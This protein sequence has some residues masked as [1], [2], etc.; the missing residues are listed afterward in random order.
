[1]IC[2]P[3]VESDLK[4]DNVIINMEPEKLLAMVI[5]SREYMNCLEI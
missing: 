5:K 1:M 2:S 3:Y 4:K